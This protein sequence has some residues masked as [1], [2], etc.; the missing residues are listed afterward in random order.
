MK[1]RR[2]S[3][4]SRLHSKNTGRL[5]VPCYSQHMLR[6]C[7]LKELK[8]LVACCSV[9]TTANQQM[10][11]DYGVGSRLTHTH[12]TLKL[13][14]IAGVGLVLLTGLCYFDFGG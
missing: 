10:A 1:T 2:T 12:T 8:E 7:Y 3:V 4:S 11:N 9:G 5:M 13:P 6:R 14:S